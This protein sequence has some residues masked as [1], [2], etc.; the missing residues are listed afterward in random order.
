MLLD[1]LIKKNRRYTP[2]WFMRQ[3]GRHLTEYKKLRNKEQN[4][5]NFCLNEKLV[6]KSSLL[7]L[8]Y[9]DLDAAILFSDILIIPWLLGQKVDF[10]QN[11]GPLLA[12]INFDTILK[13]PLKINKVHC[14]GN[15]IK[16]IKN[17]LNKNK[18]LIGFAGA[19]WTLICYMIEGGTSK[20]FEKVRKHLWFENKLFFTLFNKLIYSVVDFLEF[21][22]NSGCDVLMIFDTW[23]HMIPNTYWN[24]LAIDPTRKIVQELRDRNINCPIIG[25]PFKAGEKFVRYS[26]ESLVDVVSLDWSADL[27]WM[28]RNINSEVALQ[29]NLDPMILTQKNFNLLKNNVEKVL[30]ILEKRVHIFNLGHGITPEAKVESIIEIINCVRNTK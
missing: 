18:S 20:N 2:I 12:P 26:Y 16:E 30:S 4:F 8:K 13:N 3:S 24:K 6:I 11:H 22:A 1:T 23:S 21:Q 25:F 5:I 14:I 28:E 10:K 29:G 15:A 27:E 7:P 17:S 9:Y 19:P